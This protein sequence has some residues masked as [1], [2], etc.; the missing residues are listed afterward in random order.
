M[1]RILASFLFLGL[2]GI[3]QL[4][5]QAGLSASDPIRF[6]DIRSWLDD[7]RPSLALLEEA[8]RTDMLASRAVFQF[9]TM[10]RYVQFAGQPVSQANLFHWTYQGM[11]WGPVFSA[12]VWTPPAV[13]IDMI[14][15]EEGSDFPMTTLVWSSV[16]MNTEAQQENVFADL[17][18]FNIVFS[19]DV[20]GMLN[21]EA[22][23]LDILDAATMSRT[24]LGLAIKVLESNFFFSGFSFVHV[25]YLEGWEAYYQDGSGE[26]AATTVE[27]SNGIT[28]GQLFFYNNFMDFVSLGA[29]INL[30]A[31]ELLEYLGIGF[32]FNLF[33]TLRP[34]FFFTYIEGL[35]RLSLD[36]KGDIKILDALYFHWKWNIPLNEWRPIDDLRA[37]LTLALLLEE[38]DEGDSYF[39]LRG[40]YLTYYR[41]GMQKQG[42][43]AELGWV[44]PYS[45]RLLVGLS[46][47][48]DEVIKRLPMSEDIHVLHFRAEIGM[49]RNF[50][51]K[52][53]ARKRDALG[54]GDRE[55]AWNGFW[56]GDE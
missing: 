8:L 18:R 51:S 1:K 46:M 49:D 30:G 15:S 32:H 45:I 4:S 29:L 34:D 9:A 5:A 50:D 39:V 35:Q 6:D 24:Y 48:A 3:S 20:V 22:T 41:D 56:E 38:S 16:M 55:E 23:M 13:A 33:E 27:E 53:N 52:F 10:P 19:T 2:L 31:E 36:S 28:T 26:T 7:A 21:T 40:D 11:F 25:P 37:G 14:G 12:L 42:Y 44:L 17:L 54:F 43:F 47:N